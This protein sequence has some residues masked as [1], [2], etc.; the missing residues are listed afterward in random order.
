MLNVA[1]TVASLSLVSPN[2]VSNGVTLFFP[3]KSDDLF[4]VI[5]TSSHPLRLPT[6]RLFSVLCK[7][8]HTTFFTFI[9]V[10]PLWADG[11]TR[12]SPPPSSPLLVTPLSFD[13]FFSSHLAMIFGR[14]F[15]ETGSIYISVLD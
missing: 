3:Q 13:K 10:S 9:T 12:D 4:L 6:L 2:A 5:V 7:F 8:D 1:W 15:Y 11:V 14:P